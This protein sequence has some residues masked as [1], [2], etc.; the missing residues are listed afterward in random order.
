MQNQEHNETETFEQKINEFMPFYKKLGIVVIIFSTLV[1]S[2]V[3]PLLILVSTTDTTEHSIAIDVLLALLIISPF[4][5]VIYFY[6]Y[7]MPKANKFKKEIISDKSQF[8]PYYEKNCK[9]WFQKYL[10]RSLILQL[11]GLQERYKLTHDV[12]EELAKQYDELVGDVHEY[13][14]EDEKYESNLAN[15]D[16]IQETEELVKLDEITKEL[17]DEKDKEQK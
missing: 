17:N 4:G 14:T 9:T 16:K 11:F 8:K 7:Y 3:I 5:S 15:E 2:F 1:L 6:A 13:K 12:P 10:F